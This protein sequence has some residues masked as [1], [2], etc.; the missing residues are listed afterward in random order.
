MPD[1]T[2]LHVHTQYSILDG[3]AKITSL[4]DKTKSSGMDALAITDHGNMYGVMSFITEAKE[5]N[6]KPIIG[7]EVY[8][9]RKG[10]S[11][12]STK[13]DRS[14][15]H[16]ILLA[17]NKIGY[18]NLSRLVSMGFRDGFY[19][20]PRIDK[21][22]L[23]QYSEGIIACSACLGG[24]ISQAILKNNI[25]KA[26]DA[27]LEYLSIFGSDFYLELQR[28]GLEEQETVNKS[29]LELANKHNVKVIATNDVHYINKE[30]FE[31]HNILICLNTGR[32]VDD[33]DGMVYSGNEY[34]KTPEEMEE[35]FFD[36]PEALS[37]TR[38]L[39]E[40]VE[41]YDLE[42]NVM[43]P[44]FPLPPEFTCE[45]EYLEFLTWKGAEKKYKEVTEEV[46]ERLRHE[47]S[48]IKKMGFAGYFLIVQD[49]I[50]EARKMGVLVGPGRGSAAGSA[51]AFCVG[52]TN[53]DPIK[54]NL[55][56]ER[57]LNP[58]RVTLP[59]VDIDFDDEGREKVIEYVV[60]KYGPNRVAQIVTFGTMAA[61]SAIKDV[62]RVLKLPLSEAEKLTKL[63]P[64]NQGVSLQKAFKDVPELA[65]YKK[66][67]DELVQK[68]LAFAEILE[69]SARQ[70]GTH[71]CGVIIGP[72]DLINHVP[73]STSKDSLLLVTQYD[74][75]NVEKVGLLKMDF[76]G[77]KTLSIIK[78]TIVNIFKR[79]GVKIDIDK[80][81]WDDEKTFE[82]YKRGDTVGTFQ[83]ESEGMR[84]YLK[85]LKP[86]DIEDLIAM[87][88][89]YRPG[90]MNYIPLF[91]DRKHGR[92]KVEYPHEMLEEI[93]KP[94]HGIMVYQEQIMQAAQIMG[95][96]TLENA[97]LLRQAMS[98]KLP[99]EMLKHR[100]LFIKGAIEKGIE[101]KKA[102]E[103]FSIMEKFA[104]YGFNRSHSAAYSVVAYQTAYLKAH[105]P[106]DFMAAV[107][108]HNLNDIKKITF[109]IEATKQS[110]INVLGPDINESEMKFTV[111]KTGEIRFGLGA[112]KNV[113]EAAVQ[114]II[115]ERKQ[116]GAFTSIFDM[117]KRA[118]LR[119]I[120]KR[121]FESLAIAGAFDSYSDTH[122]AQ[123]FF[124]SDSED[125]TFLE[126]VI[127]H[128]STYQE[129]ISA[130]QQ[131]LF[132]G[133][134]EVKIPEPVMPVC[135]PWS[136]LDQL[137]NEKEVIGFYIS[138]HP[139]D[140]FKVEIENFTNLT[141]E[142]LNHD[143]KRYKNK[144]IRFAGIVTQINQR[145]TKTNKP[146][147]ALTLEDYSG[148]MSLM[149]FSENYLRFKHL[150]EEGNFL[151]IRGNVQPKYK[152][153]DQLEIK[154]NDIMLLADVLE[155]QVSK[156]SIQ[157]DLKDL[158][159]KFIHQLKEMIVTSKG[160]CKVIFI[161]KDNVTKA[162]VQMHSNKYRI[163][164]SSF[165][166]K[167]SSLKN[168][169][170]RIN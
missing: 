98:K 121:C 9:A 159:E 139:L 143:L 137:K 152:Q 124:K 37:N 89:L 162:E 163:E 32:E 47:L 73:L 16:L 136:K 56:F 106:A 167:L 102:A 99:E 135:R 125:S 112:I 156:I 12:K 128:G 75:K 67:G 24:E 132:G 4:L 145:I 20:T 151:Y 14:G 35:L 65:E 19:Y 31:A 66:N 110:D 93:L 40:K 141:L 60:Q 41:E 127:K 57:F 153:E 154:V 82:L 120:N 83:F 119:S 36:I 133:T 81:P 23:K 76:L 5:R 58:H 17:K 61:R 130:T 168:I 25:Q 15:Y 123:Y 27:I 160:G 1:F 149:L 77:L 86:T 87:N 148:T 22:W 131:S 117:V 7:C 55:L 11:S 78:D 54:Y 10:Y 109:F 50:N 155:K 165:L 108:T 92:Q 26:E 126:K 84:A 48:T 38:E 114:A 49:F 138:G 8:I 46:K 97:D 88:A 169:G 144:T 6:I 68:T 3:A 134:N 107:L 62:A 2:H 70:T 158:D 95:G 116:N 142:N 64:D 30:D 157:V 39:V 113:G 53:I 100:E 140:D 79:H 45:D 150:L 21:E 69:G 164:C 52:I 72:E 85:E 105:Y 59:D 33:T 166:K 129:R 28:H 118:N 122:R 43:L 63:V 51:V 71:A 101:E 91:I 103:V 111:N 42:R 104:E 44:G 94:T 146:F 147:G 29:I 13:E 90:P 18:Y 74:G 34:L 80:I 170:Y 115:E 161:V 96:F